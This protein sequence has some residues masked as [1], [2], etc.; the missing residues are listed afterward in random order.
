MSP[1]LSPATIAEKLAVPVQNAAA[2]WP[3]I[4]AGLEEL[5]IGSPAVQVAAA[6][7]VAVET[8]TFQPI[9][10]YGGRTPE[11]A[12]AYFTRFYEGRA[13]LGNT[14][15]G[16]GDR[17]HGRGF[18]Q[19]TG[20]ANYRL[21]GAKLGLDLENRPELALDS[22]AASRILAHFFRD[23]GI[24]AAAEAGNWELVRHRVNGGMNGWDHF[25]HCVDSLQEALHG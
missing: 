23:R 3:H 11:A 7:T 9:N 1:L 2:H 24:P 8:G 21:F 20:R 4:V 19:L 13:D 25:K 22:V 12:R 6:A 14:Q 17:F 5:G 18:V 10:E 15:R 16:D